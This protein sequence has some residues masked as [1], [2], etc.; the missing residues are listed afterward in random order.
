M[1]KKIDA[2]GIPANGASGMFTRHETP[3][4]RG[5]ASFDGAVDGG[6]AV[7]LE[8][9][10]TPAARMKGLMGREHLP[11]CCGMVFTDLEGGA[12]W[13]KGCKIPLDIVFLDDDDDVSLMYS[14]EVDEGAERYTYGD[15]KTAIELPYGFLAGHGISKGTHCKWRTW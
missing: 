11:A 2:V 8:V 1:T 6:A 5:F 10:D 14:M 3:R 12:F 9:A 4:Y 15:E 7:L 13:M